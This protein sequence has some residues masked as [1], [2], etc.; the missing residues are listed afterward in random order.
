MKLSIRNRSIEK[1]ENVYTSVCVSVSMP[2]LS[3][4]EKEKSTKEKHT[5]SMEIFGVVFCVHQW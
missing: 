4:Q 5:I 3:E 1:K 2:L